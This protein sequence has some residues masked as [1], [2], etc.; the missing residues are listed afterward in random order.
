MPGA[1]TAAAFWGAGMA[2]PALVLPAEVWPQHPRRAA[3]Q[4]QL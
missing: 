2:A 1:F 3:A 4:G